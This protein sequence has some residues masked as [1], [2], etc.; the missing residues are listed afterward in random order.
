MHLVENDLI[1][2]IKYQDK[3]KGYGYIGQKD[4]QDI[5]FRHDER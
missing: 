3:D 2:T 5:T 4:D 1:G